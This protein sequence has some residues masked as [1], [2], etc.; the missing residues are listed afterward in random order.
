MSR[1]TIHQYVKLL[2]QLFLIEKL[3]PWFANQLN[4]LIKTPKLHIGDTG[5]AAAMLQLGPDD[6]CEDRPFL[7]QLLESFVFR[8]LQAQAS[9]SDRPV[10]FHHYRDKDSYEVDFVLESGR[11]L[12]GVEVKASSTVTSSDFAGLRRLA[13]VVSDRFAAGV[14]LYDGEV[15]ASFGDRLFAVP[16]RAL[17]E[18]SD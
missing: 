6:I 13:R 8:E 11:M 18:R 5:I 3:Q 10:R 9:A 16:I 4:R 12:A 14:L 2:E 15:Q 17:W 7:G 1:N